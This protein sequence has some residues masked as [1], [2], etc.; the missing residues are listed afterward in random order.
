MKTKITYLLT[1]FAVL[2]LFTTEIF[3]CAC[4]ADRGHYSLSFKKPDKYMLGEMKDVVFA[5]ANI[6]SPS[7]MTPEEFVKGLK[8]I[9]ESYSVDGNLDSAYW[10]FKLKDNKNNLGILRLP[11]PE[12]MIHYMVDTY[13]SPDSRVELYKEL[14]FKNKVT[15]GTG[16]FQNK[17]IKSAEYFLV[18]QGSGNACTSSDDFKNWR[19]E[20]T[21]KDINYVFTGQL[22][23][24]ESK[25]SQAKN[26]SSANKIHTEN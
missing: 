3:A 11:M 18:L 17:N 6:F 16:I 8:P 14:R 10:N 4:C 15:A 7:A 5:T 23:G 12:R 22:A 25:G 2:L 9:G 19:L 26:T 1:L 21:G 24:R 13:T 20:I